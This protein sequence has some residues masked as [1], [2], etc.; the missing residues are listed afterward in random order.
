MTRARVLY[1]VPTGVPP[2]AVT[3]VERLEKIK[4]SPFTLDKATDGLNVTFRD[5]AVAEITPQDLKVAMTLAGGG[6]LNDL[7]ENGKL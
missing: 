5:K 7:I 3:N 4:E 1:A 6:I 2:T